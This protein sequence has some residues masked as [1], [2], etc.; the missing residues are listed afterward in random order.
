MPTTSDPSDPRLTHGVDENPTPMADTYLILPPD[1]L[2]GGFVRPVRR[3]YIHSTCGGRTTMG[4]TLAQTYA[5]R[6]TFYSTTFCVHCSKHRPVG[7]FT[8]DDGSGQLVGS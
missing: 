8:W 5:K 6:P 1:E 4:L 3:A 7:E 2:A